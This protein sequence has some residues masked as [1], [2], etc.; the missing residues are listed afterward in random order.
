MHGFNPILPDVTQRRIVIGCDRDTPSELVRDA[1][2]LGEALTLQGNHVAFL[3]GDPV[4]FVE[5]AG[6]WTPRELYQ[7]PVLGQ[8]PHLV[9][10]R[11]PVD[12]LADHM[13]TV[14]LSDKQTLITLASVWDSQLEKLKPDIIIGLLTP[15]LWL[16]G[17]VHA[18]TFAFGS[19]Y[20]LPP[21]LGT[22]FPRFSADSTPLADEQAMVANANAVLARFGQ[23]AIAMLSEVLSRCKSLLYGISFFDPYLQLRSERSSGVLG[24]LPAP[25]LPPV[26]RRLAAF[27]D[28]NCPGIETVILALAGLGSA[29]SDV[30][31]TRD[32]KAS[33][34]R[35]ALDICIVGATVAM[36]RFLQEQPNVAF[37]QDYFSMLEHADRASVVMHHGVQDVA[38]HCMALGRPQIILP[39]TREQEILSYSV[40]YTGFSS[41]ISPRASIQE[42][43]GKIRELLGNS[44]LVIAAQH[45]ARQLAHMDI[46]NAMPKIM[47][48]I[49]EEKS[50]LAH[51]F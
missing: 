50:E 22:S 10:K 5:Q 51:S 38:Q 49:Q 12:G 3:V 4:G 7:A 34:A 23:P 20:S 43:G 33:T 29:K 18:P 25:A 11:P 40:G 16:V 15:V 35:V 1:L 8:A 37:W 42:I 48:E 2:R 17:P 41:C 32:V 14:G 44:S 30:T 26:E 39:W 45:H 46:P 47:R 6:S 24:D 31:G 36:R 28:V 19:G 9:M 21:I 27:L 13:S